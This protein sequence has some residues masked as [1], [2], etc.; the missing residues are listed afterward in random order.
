MS[1]I[2][3]HLFVLFILFV[4]LLETKRQKYRIGLFIE[5]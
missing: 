4:K 2:E 1:I 5:E 3:G